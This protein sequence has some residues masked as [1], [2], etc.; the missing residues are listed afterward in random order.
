MNTEETKLVEDQCANAVVSEEATRGAGSVTSMAAVHGD[1]IVKGEASELVDRRAKADTLGTEETTTVRQ[2]PVTQETDRAED[3]R[4]GW[5]SIVAALIGAAEDG[6][7]QGFRIVLEEG[8]VAPSA[9]PR[10][11]SLAELSDCDDLGPPT[12]MECPQ[13]R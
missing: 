1:S 8:L 4:L 12:D 5:P 7:V 10:T 6:D 9:V 11:V 3:I 2:A 13:L